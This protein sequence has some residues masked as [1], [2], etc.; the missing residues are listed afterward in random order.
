MG[1]PCPQIAALV[2]WLPFRAHAH[3]AHAFTRSER[4]RSLLP[5]HDFLR[6][7]LLA[8]VALERLYSHP[9]MEQLLL[10]GSE[11]ALIYLRA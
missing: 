9:K 6:N 7:P 5:W 10:A 8:T 1:T 11:K 2:A 4:V 3:L